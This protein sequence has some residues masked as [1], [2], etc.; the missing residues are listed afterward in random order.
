MNS[1]RGCRSVSSSGPSGSSA[2]EYRILMQWGSQNE[3][4]RLHLKSCCKCLQ[5]LLSSIYFLFSGLKIT[6][7]R[8]FLDFISR[9]KHCRRSRLRQGLKF[10]R[11]FLGFEN[12][13]SNV[14]GILP[15]LLPRNKQ[16]LQMSS[17]SS[18]ETGSSGIRKS[19]ICGP[20]AYQSSHGKCGFF[21]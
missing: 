19:F 12:A 4:L 18:R 6:Y 20:L 1:G 2:S 11:R 17:I 14:F 10:H 5:G 15:F 13:R 21:A 7:W 3:P 16:C 9:K 8:H